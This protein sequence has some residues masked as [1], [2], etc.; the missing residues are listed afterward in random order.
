MK[1]YL[2]MN[3]IVFKHMKNV[4][5]ILCMHIICDRFLNMVMELLNNLNNTPQKF[6]SPPTSFDLI[7]WKISGLL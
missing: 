4:Y 1:A 3:Y 6:A 5:A 7:Q 2:N